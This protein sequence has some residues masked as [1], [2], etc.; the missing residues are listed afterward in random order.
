[1]EQKGKLSLDL[2]REFSLTIKCYHNVIH[3]LDLIILKLFLG[4]CGRSAQ[5]ETQSVVPTSTTPGAAFADLYVSPHS[6]QHPVTFDLNSRCCC[7]CCCCCCWSSSSSS[8]S[9]SMTIKPFCIP[10]RPAQRLWWTWLY[11]H[12]LIFDNWFH[13]FLLLLS[14]SWSASLLFLL[15]AEN[16]CGITLPSIDIHRLLSNESECTEIFQ[17]YQS[18]R[19]KWPI[20][21]LIVLKIQSL[22]VAAIIIYHFFLF[23]F[24]NSAALW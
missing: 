18:G 7:C 14:L 19:P 24:P 21:R 17:L 6:R 23:K 5:H 11:F 3:F 13:R 1:M 4:R 10:Y 9:S 2:Q 8:S 16:Q 20:Y 15:H 12:R 22:N